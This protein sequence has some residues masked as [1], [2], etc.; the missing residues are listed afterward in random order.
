[1]N[2]RRK[3]FNGR[4]DSLKVRWHPVVVDVLGE[5]VSRP[6]LFAIHFSKIEL[7]NSVSV[8]RCL[9]SID[10][11]VVAVYPHCAIIVRDGEGEELPVESLLA[12][13]IPEELHDS[14]HSNSHVVGVLA[15]RDVECCSASLDFARQERE[16]HVVGGHEVRDVE[17]IRLITH[18]G[19]EFVYLFLGGCLSSETNSIVRLSSSLRDGIGVVPP[20]VDTLDQAVEVFGALGSQGLPAEGYL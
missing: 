2:I 14:A 1:M 7:A 8:V 3:C 12:F 20:F 10:D 17:C 13:H 11:S 18:K 19:L 15:V 16:V 5:L 6:L 4:A 9:G